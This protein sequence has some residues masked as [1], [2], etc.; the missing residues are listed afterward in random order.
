M[1]LFV[2]GF[3]IIFFVGLVADVTCWECFRNLCIVTS[4]RPIGRRTLLL[5]GWIDLGHRQ[6]SCNLCIVTCCRP[7]GRITLAGWTDLGHRQL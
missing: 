7:I 5:A 2:K 3:H 6:L 1:H 4:C